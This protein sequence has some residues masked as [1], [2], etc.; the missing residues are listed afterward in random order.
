MRTFSFSSLIVLLF[1]VSWYANQFGATE[2]VHRTAACGRRAPLSLPGQMAAADGGDAVD[3]GDDGAT[4]KTVTPRKAAVIAMDESAL[5]AA[6]VSAARDVWTGFFEGAGLRSIRDVLDLCP[7]S[8]DD[9]RTPDGCTRLLDRL[10]ADNHANQKDLPGGSKQRNLEALCALAGELEAYAEFDRERRTKEVAEIFSTSRK[11]SRK[12]LEADDDDSSGSDEGRRGRRKRKKHRR[13]RGRRHHSSSSSGS[14]DSESGSEPS[15]RD[16]R[17]IVS[18]HRAKVNKAYAE[19]RLRKKPDDLLEL[20]LGEAPRPEERPAYECYQAQHVA[21]WSS[22]PGLAPLETPGW[23]HYENAGSLEGAKTRADAFAVVRCIMAAVE[24]GHS[25]DLSGARFSAVKPRA[26]DK[27][28]GLTGRD[29]KPITEVGQRPGRVRS[30]LFHYESRCN[31]HKLSYDS[32]L[33][34]FKRLYEE[35]LSQE[36]GHSKCTITCA[37]DT[38]MGNRSAFDPVGPVESVQESRGSSPRSVVTGAGPGGGGPGRKIPCRDF[39]VGRCEYGASCRFSHA[40]PPSGKGAGRPGGSE[41]R[42]GSRSQSPH[43]SASRGRTANAG[44][45]PHSRRG[46]LKSEGEAGSSRGDRSVAFV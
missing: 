39:A 32:S 44:T 20:L 21:L 16:M 3:L 42:G 15:S 23:W 10:K 25:V 4:D 37:V 34:V 7:A 35:R 46:S 40:D 43:R 9:D 11:A 22:V 19:D 38:L 27:V 29:G 36:M 1:F 13:K 8:G 30:F 17:K 28:V 6:C 5:R 31:K 41:G 14:S 12:R 18:K 45:T 26:C 24:N 2:L 33:A